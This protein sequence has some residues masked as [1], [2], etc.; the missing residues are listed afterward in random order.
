ML[1]NSITFVIFLAVVYALYL[2]LKH[3]A[4]NVLLIAAGYIFYGWWDWRFLSLLLLTTFTDYFASNQ[5]FAT[6]DERKRK[7][8]VLLSISCNLGVLFFFKYFNF[9]AESATDLLGLFG[10]RPD[11]F[12]LKVIL[13][14]GISFYTFQ[15]LSF[16]LDVYRR[17]IKPTRDVI[18]FC[19]FVSFFPQLLAG[20]IVRGGDL[21][22]IIQTKRKITYDLIRKGLWLIL[23][24]YFKK[25]V[26]ADNVALIAN[27]V[28]ADPAKHHGWDVLIGIYAFT[29][30]IYGDFSG[31]TDIARGVSNLFGIDLPINFRMPY[32]ATDPSDFWRRWHISLSTWLRDYLYISLGG[33]R[34]GTFK[35]YRNLLVTMLLGGLWHG[36][37]WHFVA[38]GA[39]HGLLLIVHRLLE[40]AGIWVKPGK[41]RRW[42]L[43]RIVQT[44]I[45]LHLTCFGWVL[46]RINKLADL[47]ILAQSLFQPAFQNAH[48]VFVLLILSLPLLLIELHNL[49]HEDILSVKRIPAWGRIAIYLVLFTYILLFSRGDG[50]EFIYFQF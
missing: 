47:P 37:A 35:T 22:P 38:W 45:M 31:Y 17:E 12:T 50:Y 14:V 27:D 16:T 49:R 1:F 19:A 28:F 24:G 36:A 48:W 46:F 7:L 2:S 34:R 5:I 4:Q 33:N 42:S 44:L 21:L 25:I 18:D 26:L 13:P 9:F 6:E 43:R 39:Y 41:D 10:F 40:W 20:P 29:L 15:S 30:Q 11:P 32:F 23:L 8:Y 3:R